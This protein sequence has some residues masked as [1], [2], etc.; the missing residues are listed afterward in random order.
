MTCLQGCFWKNFPT[1]AIT[2][3][4]SRHELFSKQNIEKEAPSDQEYW[5][6]AEL[7]KQGDDYR[8]I[9]HFKRSSLL[10]SSQ[11]Q[12]V[13]SALAALAGYHLAQQAPQGLQY[14]WSNKLFKQIPP[15]HPYWLDSRL[16]ASQ[17]AIADLDYDS[18]NEIHQQMSHHP[19]N[20]VQACA[21]YVEL[22]V[23]LNQYDPLSLKTWLEIQKNQAITID[24]ETQSSAAL[25]L[26]QHLN[27]AKSPTTARWLNAILPGAGYF[28]VGQKSSAMTSFL[29]NTLFIAASARFFDRGDI[30]AGV[31]CTSFEL[32]WYIGGING[33]GI[34]AIEY[35]QDKWMKMSHKLLNEHKAFPILR[36]EHAF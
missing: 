12:Q 23:V 28:Y 22:S 31:L 8:A 15:E 34:A 2:T 17:L 9:T 5:I 32:G 10:A 16:L 19:H 6:G 11:E 13:Q 14:F 7:A 26:Q 18:L 29:L 3:Q 35:N 36:L 1:Q 27:R 30:A 20:K 24:Q 4:T 33:A 21:K 25:L